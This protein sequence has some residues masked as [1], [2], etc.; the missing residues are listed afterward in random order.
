MGGR[1]QPCLDS[2]VGCSHSHTVTP[3][4]LFT[5]S[6][7]KVKS[8]LTYTTRYSLSDGCFTNTLHGSTCLCKLTMIAQLILVLSLL[9]RLWVK[10]KIQS[11]PWKQKQIF[12]TSFVGKLLD[13]VPEFVSVLLKLQVLPYL[14]LTC[15]TLHCAEVKNKTTYN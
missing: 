8:H 14:Y 7:R 3:F 2:H 4:K 11:H 6:A 5:L 15:L 1:W 12:Q 10:K 9:D 13:L